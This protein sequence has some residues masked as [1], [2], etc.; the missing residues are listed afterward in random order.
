MKFLCVACDQAMKLDRTLA[1]EGGTLAVVFSC[2]SCSRETAMLTNAMETQ[3]VRSLGVKI[4]GRTEPV[5]PMEMVRSSLVQVQ[6]EG[7]APTSN[8]SPVAS[9]PDSAE[10]VSESKCPFTSVAAEAFARNPAP[11]AWTAEAEERISRVPPFAQPM[12]RKG[13][14]LHARE[15]GY[16]EITDAVIDEVKDRFGM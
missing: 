11:I 14:E 16:E 6:G 1:P 4:G 8:A 3:M 9:S 7:A 15:H 10:A 13:V 5:E 12:A 2:P